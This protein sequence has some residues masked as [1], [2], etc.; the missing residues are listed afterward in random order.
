M[1][2]IKISAI[3]CTSCILMNPIIDQIKDKYNMKLIEYDYDTDSESYSK[4]DIG[5]I[6][7]VIIILDSNDNEITRIIGEKSKKELIDI[8]GDL[9][10]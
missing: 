4:Y 2:M 7:P 3:W 5:S 10:G 9:N 8:I 6:L 1:K